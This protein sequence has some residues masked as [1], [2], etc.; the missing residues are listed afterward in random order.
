MGI[1]VAG[2]TAAAMPNRRILAPVAPSRLSKPQVYRDPA[3]AV[4]RPVAAAYGPRAI[5]PL[6][7]LRT[8]SAS[9]VIP[10]SINQPSKKLVKT[11]SVVS[12]KA[13]ANLL[14]QRQIF[15]RKRRAEELPAVVKEPPVKMARPTTLTRAVTSVRPEEL[16]NR[17]R[18]ICT[19]DDTEYDMLVKRAKYPMKQASREA[20]TNTHNISSRAIRE[21]SVADLSKYGVELFTKPLSSSRTAGLSRSD[22]SGSQDTVVDDE[23][24]HGLPPRIPIS[25]PLCLLADPPRPLVNDD[26]GRGLPPRIPIPMAA[27]RAFSASLHTRTAINAGPSRQLKRSNTATAAVVSAK[28]TNNAKSESKV[29]KDAENAVRD[30]D[31]LD[32]DDIDDPMM[33][34][35]YINEIIAYMRELE[36]KT[37]ADPEYA[38]GQSDITWDMRRMLIDW[39]ILI[40][41]QFRMLP[42]TLY[43]AINILDRFMS[44][45]E[46]QTTSFQL[47]GFTSLMIA[48][49]YEESSTPNTKDFIF[50]AGGSYTAKEVK[51]AELY[52]LEAI[53]FDLSFPNHMAFLR[54]ISKA[55]QYNDKTRIIAKYLMEITLLDHRHIKY[56]P[57][58]I[59]AS[60]IYAARRIARAGRWN[61]NMRHFSGYTKKELKPCCLL[62]FRFIMSPPKDAQFVIKKYRGDNFLRASHHCYNWVS[63]RQHNLLRDSPNLQ[64]AQRAP[65][66]G[67]FETHHDLAQPPAMRHRGS[68]STYATAVEFDPY[69]ISVND[70]Q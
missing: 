35:E 8:S 21:A 67:E 2:S 61:A 13:E 54:R 4:P 31:D 14:Q 58:M 63:R 49:K 17:K 69:P 47:I 64:R 51:Q 37:M 52:I 70:T 43:L 23:S 36:V 1:S 33:V 65:V 24:D 26:S 19:K 9:N 57:S 29:R 16:A 30:W 28:E 20:I 27:S 68:G 44:K 10:V 48:C 6:R 22:T 34:S 5:R 38:L 32:A 7:L 15:C 56:P 12:I 40:H 55:E 62:M 25:I 18:L 11:G 60:A 50:L 42:E 41:W 53:D 46:V 39:I 66:Y 59:A 3:P 45:V